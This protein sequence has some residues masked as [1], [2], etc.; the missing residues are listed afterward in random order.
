M[1]TIF[2]KILSKELSVKIAYEDETVLAFHDINPQAPIHVL[3]IPKKKWQRFADFVKAE[4]K[5]VG[6][7][8]VSVAKAAE[9]LGLDKNG[10]RIVFNNGRD[11]GQTV[12]YIH[13]HILGGRPMTWPPG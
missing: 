3:A 13:A 9:H 1:S 10:Y 6:E 5:A 4:P 11:G 12:D 2:D 7:Y 8:M